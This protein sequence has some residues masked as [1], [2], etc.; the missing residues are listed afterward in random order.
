MPASAVD[1][2]LQC[3][4]SYGLLSPS[5]VAPARSRLARDELSIGVCMGGGR[6]D[7]DLSAV[8]G[9]IVKAGVIAE[10]RLLNYLL[11]VSEQ[12]ARNIRR[13]HWSSNPWDTHFADIDLFVGA[14]GVM[15]LEALQ[16]GVPVIEVNT[17]ENLMKNKDLVAEGYY[18]QVNPE[19]T[20]PTSLVHLIAKI[21][22]GRARVVLSE[23]VDKYKGKTLS[24]SVLRYSTQNSGDRK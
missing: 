3:S 9:A 20:N 18:V 19:V 1:D 16:R 5:E 11:P 17:S 22:D 12:L 13:L 4:P 8:F 6:T 23:F 21:L 15:C 2:R 10:I 7:I 14:G 24:E